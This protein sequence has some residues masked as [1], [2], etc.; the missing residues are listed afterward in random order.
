MELVDALTGKA[1]EPKQGG[2]TKTIKKTLEPTWN[3]RITWMGV[4]GDPNLL[5]IKVAVYDADM[6]TKENL[7]E[8]V[9]PVKDWPEGYV[10]D[11]GWYDL[12]LKGVTQGAVQVQMRRDVSKKKKKLVGNRGKSDS[13]GG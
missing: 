8:V 10:F 2:K 6:I 1:V 12:S 11:D 7:G 3:E 9:I 5:A 4:K 13:R